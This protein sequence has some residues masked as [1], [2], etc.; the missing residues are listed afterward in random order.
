M[1]QP[2]FLDDVKVDVKANVYFEGKVVSH[3]VT[4]KQGHKKTL[5]LIY[6]GS[7]TFNTQKPEIMQITSGA[8]EVQI[9]G[10]EKTKIKAGEEFQV[11]GQSSFEISVS[12]GIAEY[13]CIFVEA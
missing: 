6:P 13:L 9:A 7:Y 1:T 3:S 10:C 12:E 5:G 8:C 4:D 11:P 2:Q